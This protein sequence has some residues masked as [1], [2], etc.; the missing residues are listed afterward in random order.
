MLDGY[1]NGVRNERYTMRTICAYK[2]LILT[3]VIPIRAAAAS[4][5]ILFLVEALRRDDFR[6]AVDFLAFDVLLDF[7]GAMLCVLFFDYNIAERNM[8]SGRI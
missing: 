7:V 3:F 5:H 8:C 4:A 1:S 2:P 6:V